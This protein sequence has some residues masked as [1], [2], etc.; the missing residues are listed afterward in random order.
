M[1]TIL[2]TLG[3]LKIK[4]FW[5]K[6]Y[7][8]I[9]SGHDVTKNILSLESNYIV[10]VV[11]WP[12]F[13]NSGFSMREVN[14]L[15]FEGWSWFKFNNLGLA[16]GMASKFYTSVAKGLKLKDKV[17]GANASVCRSYREK[18]LLGGLFATTAHLLFIL[19]WVKREICLTNLRNNDLK[20]SQ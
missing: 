20:K 11:M 9:I 5:N 14:D 8:V 19:N 10:H 16:Q 17:L 4:V 1:V 13:G 2:A 12:K 15:N 18:K 6:G 3:L 7:D